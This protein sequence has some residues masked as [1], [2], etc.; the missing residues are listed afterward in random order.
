[1]PDRLD[2]AGASLSPHGVFVA[3]VISFFIAEIGDKTQIAT[4]ALAAGYSILMAV[5][6]VGMLT[7]N[8]PVVL[9]GNAFAARLPMR[10]IHIGAALL[11]VGLGLFFLARGFG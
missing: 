2:G 5:T 7:A 10:A 8:V 3:T 11:F 6:T 4:V 9:L 1:M